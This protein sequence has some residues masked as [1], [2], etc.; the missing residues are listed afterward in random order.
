MTKNHINRLNAPKA[1]TLFK[2]E[3]KWIAKPSPGPHPLNK[4]VTLNMILKNILKYTKTTKE[5][6]AI[7]NKG[8]VKVDNII[9]KDHKFPVGLMDIV[10]IEETKENFRVLFNKK[11]KIILL[12]I[13]KE[14][15]NIKPRKIINKKILKKNRLQLNFFDGTNL[16][17]KGKFETNDTI[18]FDI[19][20]NEPKETLKMEKGVIVYI[21]DGKK[22]GDI[23]ILKEI[24]ERKGLQPAKIIFTKDKKD[25]ETLKDYVFVIGKNKPI[26]TL[27]K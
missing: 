27:E 6:K 3:T 13:K 14:E 5:V 20:K 17:T 15:S 26:I 12:P 10:T 4:A 25:F 24:E 23:G 11:G 9:R 1:W 8:L 18:V 16:I 7:L 2:K 21:I 22:I 19:A